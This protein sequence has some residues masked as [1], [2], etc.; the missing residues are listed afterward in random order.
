MQ[1]VKRSF[2]K[3]RQH[4][5]KEEYRR[6]GCWGKTKSDGRVLREQRC[7]VTRTSKPVKFWIVLL[8]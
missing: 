1:S 7:G 8:R 4:A 2:S 3:T 5:V 6:K